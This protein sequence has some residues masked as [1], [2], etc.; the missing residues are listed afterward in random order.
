M[1]CMDYRSTSYS[2]WHAFILVL[3]C[4]GLVSQQNSLGSWQL[5]H[6]ENSYQKRING[7]ALLNEESLKRETQRESPERNT[8]RNDDQDP[9]KFMRI[10][11]NVDLKID[12]SDSVLVVSYR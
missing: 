7:Q 6:E 4:T 3:T 11:G 12:F 1:E 2:R 10:L 9:I 5:I 8:G